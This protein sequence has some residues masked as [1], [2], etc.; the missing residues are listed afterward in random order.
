MSLRILHV[1]ATAAPGS[2]GPV[3]GVKQLTRVNVTMGH[4]VEVATLDDPSSPWLKNLGVPV[5]AL[6]PGRGLYH[7]SPKFVPWLK[8]NARR[9]DCVVVNGVWQYNLYG[10][11]LALRDSDVPYF[12][13]THGMLDPWFK[14]R[15]PLKHLKKWLYWPWAVYP[16]LQQARAVFFTCEE[17]RRLARESFWLY[18][19]REFV[20][21]YGTAGAPD[22]KDHREAFLGA[23]PTLRGKRL[24]LFLGRIAPKKGPD[25]FL[26][27]AAKLIAEGKCDRSTLRLVMAGPV[28]EAYGATLKELARKLGIEDLVY[29]PGLLL[30][31]Q[32]WGAFQAA[33]AFVLPSHQENF[34]IAVAESLSAGTPVL[35]G[36]G[37]NTW[38]DIVSDGAGF[39]AEPSVAGCA[40]VLREWFALPNER[41]LAMRTA[42]R[43][44]FLKRYTATNAANTFVA[45]L[46][47]LT[48]TVR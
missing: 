13:F 43:E 9:F 7:Y 20:V 34:G 23:H 44:C 32:K 41:R 11:G 33:E 15:Y 6:G 42:A 10:T 39:A 24:L 14:R 45:A 36:T 48:R 27:A 21:H 35:L 25:F 22:D 46:Y 2:G 16:V 28:D 29:W 5:T 18:D 1:L 37:V 30:G 8:E 26:K 19:C 12:V 17:E 38:R 4:Y 31:D 40:Q 3:E 47:L